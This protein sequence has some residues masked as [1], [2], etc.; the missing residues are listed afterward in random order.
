MIL[1]HIEKKETKLT[2]DAEMY[3]INKEHVKEE[4]DL[5]KSALEAAVEKDRIYVINVCLVS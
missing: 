3:E 5:K 2:H 4:N 1:C